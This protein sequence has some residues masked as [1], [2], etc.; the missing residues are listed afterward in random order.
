MNSGDLWLAYRAAPGVQGKDGVKQ[1]VH[2]Y[3]NRCFVAESKVGR[4]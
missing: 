2:S 4:L 3:L 1:H